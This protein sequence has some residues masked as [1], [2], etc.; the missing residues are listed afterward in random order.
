MSRLYSPAQ[1]WPDI[2]DDVALVFIHSETHV[3][4]P[5]PVRWRSSEE[6]QSQHGLF[7]E[8]AS[9]SRPL[10]GV[11]FNIAGMVVALGAHNTTPVA[12]YIGRH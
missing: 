11:Y 4:L 10:R 5:V 7:G 2:V 1:L 3:S 6:G 8:T 12:F 9:Q